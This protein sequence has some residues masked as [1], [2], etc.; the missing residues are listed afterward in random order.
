MNQTAHPGDTHG[1]KFFFFFFFGCFVVVIF[2]CPCA[3]ID[4]FA[5]LISLLLFGRNLLAVT[6]LVGSL[7]PVL[8]VQESIPEGEEGLGKVGLDTP[9]L[10][11]NVVVG[12][13]VAGDELER[14]PGERVAA[15]VVDSLDGGHGKEPHALTHSHEGGLER[16]SRAKG[17][18]EEALDGVVVQSA[19]GIRNV[20]SVVSR[21]EVRCRIK[22]AGCNAAYGSE[23]S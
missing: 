12:S 23:A 15:V 3:K 8:G 2:I 21:V 11:V 20:E 22:L 19:V 10:V 5:C 1:K 9:V 6:R 4:Q 7:S 18:E 13:I 17:V 16:D 14:V